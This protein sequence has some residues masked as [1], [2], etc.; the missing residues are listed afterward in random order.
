LACG[1]PET[2]SLGLVQEAIA[3]GVVDEAHD[4]IFRV[5]TR[6]DGLNGLCSATLI[7]PNLVITARHC[8][9]ALPQERI[10]CEEARFGESVAASDLLFSNDTAPELRSRWYAAERVVVDESSDEVCGNDVA[11]VVLA[12]PALGVPI[13]EPRQS[14]AVES[15]E[16]YSVVGYGGDAEGA[17]AEFGVRHYRDDFV[18]QC[19]GA[20]CD[21]EGGSVTAREFVGTEGVCRGDSGGPA[22]DADGRLIGVLSRGLGECGTPVY[23]SVPQFS[24]WLLAAAQS[25]ADEQSPL[26]V[27]AGGEASKPPAASEADAGADLEEPEPEPLAAEGCALARGTLPDDGVFLVGLA[28]ALLLVARRARK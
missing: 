28:S 19:V 6:K 13:T 21:P 27:W 23:A 24:G 14:P 7:A 17:E 16:A 15:A 22:L 3:D 12:E 2:A 10:I 4:S 9:S 26:P 20:P 25:A 18:V 8:V 11:L 5:I 1:A